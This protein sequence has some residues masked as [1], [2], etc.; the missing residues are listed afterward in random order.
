MYWAIFGPIGL[1]LDIGIIERGWG[2]K[3][4]FY[5]IQ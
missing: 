2:V 1:T 5:T 3:P 4:I